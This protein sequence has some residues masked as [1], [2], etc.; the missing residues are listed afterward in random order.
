MLFL[1]L[2]YLPLLLLWM[3]I[4]SIAAVNISECANIYEIFEGDSCEN[5]V[6]AFK[7]TLDNLIE[8]N[9]DLD[10][11]NLTM[12]D[13]IC[14]TH[15]TNMTANQTAKAGICAQ[16]YTAMNGDTCLLVAQAFKTDVN[17]LVQLNPGLTC[18]NL[19]ENQILCVPL[20]CGC[21]FFKTFFFDARCAHHIYFFY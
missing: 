6:L 5:I 14:V 20:V 18:P 15:D 12:G 16:Y 11:E 13:E 3:P 10:C 19:S 2:Y 17:T 9:P 8:L 4:T 7:T 21:L 1:K